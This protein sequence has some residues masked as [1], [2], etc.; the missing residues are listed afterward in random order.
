M[1]VSLAGDSEYCYQSRR[2]IP[3][4]WG[5]LTGR[6]FIRHQWVSDGYGRRVCTRCGQHQAL[7]RTSYP[8]I[9]EA[10]LNW[11][12]TWRENTDDKG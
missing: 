9:G 8:D 6:G 3:I 2:F 12:D 11:R 10:Q 7:Y 1:P 4:L 5:A